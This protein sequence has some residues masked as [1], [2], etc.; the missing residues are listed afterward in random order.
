MSRFPLPF[1]AGVI[2][3]GLAGGLMRMVAR[4]MSRAESVAIGMRQGLILL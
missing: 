3:S 4:I 1:L 2:A